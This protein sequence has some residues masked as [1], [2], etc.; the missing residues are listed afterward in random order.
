MPPRRIADPLPSDYGYI[1]M[2]I[3]RLGGTEYTVL[4]PNNDVM[5][6]AED[7]VWDIQIQASRTT[8]ARSDAAMQALVN[9]LFLDQYGDNYRAVFRNAH[10]QLPAAPQPAAPQQANNNNDDDDETVVEDDDYGEEEEQGE[11]EEEE[12][13]KQQPQQP[14]RQWFEVR[15][16]ASGIRQFWR[17]RYRLGPDDRIELAVDRLGLPLEPGLQPTAKIRVL[18]RT[19]NST[20]PAQ[21]QPIRREREVIDVDAESPVQRREVIDVDA[22]KSASNTPAR[23]STPAVAASRSPAE[24]GTYRFVLWDQVP[25][26]W[27]RRARQVATAAHENGNIEFVGLRVLPTGNFAPEQTITLKDVMFYEGDNDYDFDN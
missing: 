22:I 12:E 3:G 1:R 5:P 4:I 11:E 18:H 24:R 19:R 2:R 6:D 20:P 8:S 23:K 14:S 27:Q 10:Q 7:V 17:H 13:E 25:E 16:L 15:N 26:K 9:N 21:R